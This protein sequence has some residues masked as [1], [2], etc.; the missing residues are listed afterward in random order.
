RGAIPRRPA[1]AAGSP[2][3]A[4]R[5]DDRARVAGA[6]DTNQPTVVPIKAGSHLSANSRMDKWVLA[7]ARLSTGRQFRS[8]RADDFLDLEALDHVA[9]LDVLVI[10]E[11]HA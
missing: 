11:G 2:G 3:V 5:N 4:R 1:A 9:L 8:Q 6:S 10:L 7:F